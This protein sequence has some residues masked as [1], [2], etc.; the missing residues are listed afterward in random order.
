MCPSVFL[1]DQESLSAEGLD[2]PSRQKPRQPESRWVG[3]SMSLLFLFIFS[4]LWHTETSF[5]Q[6]VQRFSRIVVDLL[7]DLQNQ[8]STLCRLH[9]NC[10]ARVLFRKPMSVSLVAFAPKQSQP[11]L[12]SPSSSSPLVFPHCVSPWLYESS[13]RLPP[14]SMSVIRPGNLSAAFNW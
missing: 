12:P 7:A 8:N 2:V 13:L 9:L 3:Q 4:P 14:A 6:F 10:F 5:L 11:S 1:P